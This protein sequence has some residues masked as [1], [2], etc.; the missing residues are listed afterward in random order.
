MCYNNA[1]LTSVTLPKGE[2]KPKETIPCAITTTTITFVK[3]KNKIHKFQ[4]NRINNNYKK[5]DTQ[6]KMCECVQLQS[7][8]DL[9]DFRF[10]FTCNLCHLENP[11]I[12]SIKSTAR[13]QLSIC[14]NHFTQF[15]W[16]CIYLLVLFMM[17]IQSLFHA[18]MHTHTHTHTHVN[19]NWDCSEE[20]KS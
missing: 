1:A 6:P 2:I 3:N 13:Q 20:K 15:N 12:T 18:R 14:N 11:T 4:T 7:P 19:M 17:P 10:L 9:D 8:G 16:I 5:I